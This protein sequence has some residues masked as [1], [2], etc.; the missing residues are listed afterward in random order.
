MKDPYP[1]DR[2]VEQSIALVQAT[3]DEHIKRAYNSKQ[4]MAACFKVAEMYAVPAKDTISALSHGDNI[5]S[6]HFVEA[7]VDIGRE[8]NDIE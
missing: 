8:K 2:T 6:R 7:L 3:V 4:I 1:M 5:L